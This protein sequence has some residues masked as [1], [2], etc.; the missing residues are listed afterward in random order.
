[1]NGS[2]VIII[3]IIII[4]ALRTNSFEERESFKKKEMVTRIMLLRLKK[5]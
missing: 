1:M 2:C 4:K 3:I 5:G